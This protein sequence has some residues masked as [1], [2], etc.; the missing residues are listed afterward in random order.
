MADS[1]VPRRPSWYL[2]ARRTIQFASLVL[3]N[4]AFL[5]QA[6][7]SGRPRNVVDLHPLLE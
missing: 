1:S 2:R 7:S 3:V 4:A 5:F 6:R